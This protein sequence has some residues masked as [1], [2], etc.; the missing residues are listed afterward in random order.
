[1]KT[2]LL[3]LVVV[4]PAL[5]AC[6]QEVA[7]D[8]VSQKKSTII[9]GS[10]VGTDTA[11]GAVFY[12]SAGGSCTG[13]FVTP[14]HIVT[15]AHCIDR[16]RDRP[17][18]NIYYSNAVDGTG[19]RWQTIAAVH[20]HPAYVHYSSSPDVALIELSEPETTIP[21][22]AI[23]HAGAVVTGTVATVVGYGCD[24]FDGLTGSRV[25]RA[26]V[27]PVS[28]VGPFITLNVAGTYTMTVGDMP[29]TYVPGAGFGLCPGDS[30][31]P[32]LVDGQIAGISSHIFWDGNKQVYSSASATLA[33]AHAWLATFGIPIPPP[34]APPPSFYDSAGGGA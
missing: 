16:L 9:G 5:V 8:T 17:A 21:T 15:A 18:G 19:G 34:P 14:R 31:G 12:S 24:Q 3:G 2:S 4:L 10:V 30:G 25:R 11:P 1:M 33:E 20:L 26:G 32:L 6:T 28:A 27:G 13:S 23:A 29:G 7:P 22:V